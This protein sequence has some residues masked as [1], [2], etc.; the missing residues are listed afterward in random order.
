M[1]IKFLDGSI[2]KYDGE[3]TLYEIA[4][5]ISMGLAR[6]SLGAVVDGKIMGLNE[7]IKNDCSVKFVK[8]DDP[9]G[10]EI[11]W[12]TSAHVLALAV[13]RL[14]PD[15]KFAI[16]PAIENGFYYDFDLEH[17]FT[18]KDLEEIEKEMKKIIKSNYTLTKSVVNKEEAIEF[19]S[20]NKEV[21]KVDLIENFDPSEEI[22]FYQLGEFIDLCRGPHLNDLRKIKAFKL[23][24]IAGAY[25]RGDENNK[26]LQRIYGVSFEKASH[27]NQHLEF[28]E[29]AKERDH[30]KIGKELDLFMISPEVGSGLPFWLPKGATIRRIIERYIVDKEISL[31]YEHVYTPVLAN[32][33]LYVKSGHW[34]HY[35]EDMFAPMDRGDGEVLV[36]RP[37]NCPHHM[38]IFDR[39]LY[40]YRELPVR[41]AE[42]GQ[43]HRYEKRGAL[44]GLSRV[45]EMTLNDAHIFV[46]PDQIKEEFIN[47]VNLIKDVYEDFKIV[48]Y[49]F[50]ASYRD[51]NNKEKYFDDDEMWQ[52]AELMLKEA[53]DEI[54][55]PYYEAIGDAAFYGPKLDVQV[56]NALGH[57]E[58]LSTVQLDFLLPERFDLTYV[59]ED[60]ENNKRP[61]VIHR[62]VV[63]TME[64]MVSYLIE[65]YKGK[66]PLWLSPVQVKLI[67][68]SDKFNDYTVE[69]QN[70]LKKEGF[71]VEVDLRSEKVGY[72]IREAQLDKI[73]YMLVIGEKEIESNKLNVRHF[74]KGVLG[75]MEKDEFIKTLREESQ[76]KEYYE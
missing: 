48:D 57:E 23:L 68:V 72:K 9:E 44:S 27:L 1:N 12:H 18:P 75:N 20:E 38:E 11:F 17:R 61:V 28:L 15:V 21:Y 65:R 33:S 22:S 42:L 5:D 35:K 67:S 24:N 3:K 4:S 30:R 34:Q 55:E 69:L 45:R 54:N 31:G 32:S 74:I 41:I 70:E 43:M 58:T 14:W 25:W 64:R 47:I 7:T 39:R 50:R 60:G 29:E 36:L 66:F 56:K 37:M 46:R 19:F 73:P 51:P 10:K 26:M 62:G 8:F 52:K 76:S 53:L 63:S 2:T 16:G 13:L 40:S 59:G 6:N 49:K 71:R